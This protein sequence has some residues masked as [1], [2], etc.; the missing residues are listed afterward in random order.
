MHQT[1]RFA[2]A[3][4]FSIFSAAPAV[5]EQALA[6]QPPGEIATAQSPIAVE[7]VQRLAEAGPRAAVR[8]RKERDTLA[9]FYAAR[10]N[11]LLWVKPDGLTPA[12]ERAI[13]EIKRADDWGLNA[14]D[15]AVPAAINASASSALSPADQVEAELKLSIAMLK[16][17]RHAR[18]GRMD[19]TQLSNYIDRQPPL[20]EPKRVLDEIA[21]ATEPDAYL[22]K[23]NPQHPQFEKLRQLYLTMRAGALPAELAAAEAP[24]AAKTK[25]NTKV[26][27]PETGSARKVLLN[28]EQWRWMP[29]NLGAMYVWVNIPEFTL[30]M[31]RNDKVVHSERVITGK[32]ENQTPVFSDEM[33]SVVF[34]PAWGVP[35][36]IKVKELLPGL[37]RGGDALAR[38]GLRASYRGR[39]ID[40]MTIDWSTTDIRNLDIIQPPGASNVLGVV[41][42]QFPNKHDIYMHDTP[43]KD[44]FN[45]DARAFSHGCIRVRNP[46]RLAEIVMAHDQGW[47]PARIAQ[48]VNGGPPV[49][50]IRLQSKIPVHITYFTA[51]VDEAGKPQFWRDIYGNENRIQMGLEGKAHLIVKKKE[52]LGP[53]RAGIVS[54]YAGSGP[55]GP[56]AGSTPNWVR[57]I[58][59]F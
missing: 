9:A 20:L 5:A 35:N 50:L 28:M 27:R 44:L 57:N 13:A 12:A 58:F 56:G 14:A 32:P 30:R 53:L 22:R 8:N 19:P 24:A 11:E 37:M 52:D 47:G 31:V 15:F 18:G 34:H 25:T 23:L 7:L 16:Y 36:S 10:S 26:S 55:Y 40:P 43:T 45:A 39:E 49:N 4:V 38:N 29:E 48:L 21:S 42:F 46:L 2:Y 17:A 6:L 1:C 3:L 59:N 51:A 33:E 41:K 54:R